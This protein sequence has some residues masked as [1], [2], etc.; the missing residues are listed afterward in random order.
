MQES[1]T[2]RPTAPYDDDARFTGR[3]ALA[4]REAPGEPAGA[5]YSWA[6]LH[7]GLSCRSAP[8]HCSS[9]SASHSRASRSRASRSRAHLETP[10]SESSD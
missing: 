7:R 3:H 8:K 9:R 6:A 5:R 4:P 1:W 2:L 10:S